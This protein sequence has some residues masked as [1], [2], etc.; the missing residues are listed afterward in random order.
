M[1]R[2]TNYI[3]WRH[4][5]KQQHFGFKIKGKIIMENIYLKFKEKR[6]KLEQKISESINILKTKFENETGAI[7]TDIN[8]NTFTHH[9]RHSN[10]FAEIID[11]SQVI[12]VKIS[13]NVEG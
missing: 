6:E 12:G 5:N 1:G 9:A 8:I 2:T 4:P 7:I 3:F 11:R 13:T 10:G